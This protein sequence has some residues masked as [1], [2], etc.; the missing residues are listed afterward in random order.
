MS[1]TR[2]E[3]KDDPSGIRDLLL[4]VIDMV[5]SG[6]MDTKKANTIITAGNAVLGAIR[7]DVQDK[8]ILELQQLLEKVME[9]RKR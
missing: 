5:A 2:D 6:D 3:S 7:T 8:K 4:S 9:D 1:Q